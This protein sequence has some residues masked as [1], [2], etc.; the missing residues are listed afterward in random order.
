[1]SP[2]R[3]E[4]GRFWP[5]TPAVPDT[6]DLR[7]EGTEVPLGTGYSVAWAV[8]G[9]GEWW[10]W[11][12]RDDGASYPP[13]VVEAPHEETGHLPVVYEDRIFLRCGAP[14]RA[15]HLCRNPATTE[16]S[17]CHIHAR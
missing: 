15:G 14:T 11:V 7:V 4:Q 5:D 8:D 2:D 9:D 13:V 10:P 12:F 17:R 6:V 16:D 1:M 3:P